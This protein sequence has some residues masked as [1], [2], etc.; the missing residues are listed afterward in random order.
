MWKKTEHFLDRTLSSKIFTWR[1]IIDLMIPGI[2]D[3]LSIMFI[4]M[5]IT[6]L[7]S[8]NGESSVA[9]FALVSPITSLI[10]WM[11]NGIA[12]GGS[13]V[14]AQSIGKGDHIQIQRSIGAATVLTTIVGVI[15]CTVPLP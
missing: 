10:G 14:V 8:S 11:F 2:L 5:L 15:I 1:Q 4:M 6:A 9:A 12:A 3:N 13:V 7:I